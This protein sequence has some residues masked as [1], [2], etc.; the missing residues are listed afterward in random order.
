[1]LLKIELPYIYIYLLVTDLP[2]LFS[3][4][5]PGCF[6]RVCDQPVKTT[7]QIPHLSEEDE[8]GVKL[9]YNNERVGV[10]MAKY[11]TKLTSHWTQTEEEGVEMNE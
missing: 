4:K 3:I 11:T 8:D 6:E 7:Q 5:L 1:M 9:N 10:Q 2:L